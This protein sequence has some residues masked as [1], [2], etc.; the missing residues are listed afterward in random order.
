[1]T[2]EIG[3]IRPEEADDLARAVTAGFGG[4]ISDRDLQIEHH[5]QEPDRAVAARDRDLLVGGSWVVTSNVS[6]PGGVVPAAGVTG[7]A[8]LPT[9]RR[10]GI[11]TSMM[12]HI[13]D[14][15]RDREP[16]SMLWAAEGAIYGRGS[17][18]RGRS[19]SSRAT[20]RTS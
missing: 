12:R 11:L 5:V 8:V 18:G 9:H 13:L 7:V 14:D 20:R 6:V 2:V 19:S 16:V 1:M 4:H 3:G 15:L 10:R 17:R